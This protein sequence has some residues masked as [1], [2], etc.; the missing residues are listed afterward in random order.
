MKSEGVRRR[1]GEFKSK[2]TMT[3]SLDYIFKYE[4]VHSFVRLIQTIFRPPEHRCL[5]V[6]RFNKSMMIQYTFGIKIFVPFPIV[7]GCRGFLSTP[8]FVQTTLTMDYISISLL[9]RSLNR[10]TKYFFVECG[11]S[12][13]HS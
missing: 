1:L 5:L 8:P 9:P 13:R 4:T 6:K 11:R 7:L 3:Q 2:G 10:F 12:F